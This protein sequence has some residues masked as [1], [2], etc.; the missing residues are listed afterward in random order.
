MT[1]ITNA[2]SSVSSTNNTSTANVGGQSTLTSILT[3]GSTTVNVVDG[4]V[5]DNNTTIKI[6]D[7]FLNITNISVNTLTVTRGVF[8]STDVT[9]TNSSIVKGVYIG[10][11]EKNNQPDVLVSLQS[12]TQGKKYF[13][14]SDDNINWS[15]YPIYGFN[16]IPNIYSYH[17][18]VKGSRYFRI[19]FENDSTSKTT[20]F[21]LYT[22]FGLFKQTSMTS[23]GELLINS[24]ANY[25][26]CS[27]LYT[28]NGI[29]A[30]T[31]ILMID[32]NDTINYPHNN[33]GSINIDNYKIQTENE[34]EKKAV[35]PIISLG[36]ITSINA[37][38]ANISY[39]IT[40]RLEDNF[41]NISNNYQP[42]SVKFKVLNGELVDSLTNNSETTTNINTG[43]TLNTPRNIQTTPEVGDIILHISNVTSTI[44]LDCSLLYHSE[45]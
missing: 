6:D 38:E 34:N 28:Q 13:D 5:F 44:T 45:D 24:N 42:S 1:F 19:R 26:K 40:N 20:S 33:M 14:F 4:S 22:Y 35:T 39:L 15:S 16:V 36:V 2:I 32:L 7:E 11:S 23:Q 25:K 9:H 43:I 3:A 10:I 30:D 27:I 31:Y 37:T 41:F 17:T 21:R 18:A 12:D 29:N 8:N